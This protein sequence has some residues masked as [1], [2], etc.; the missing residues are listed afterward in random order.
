[1][2]STGDW[3]GS[4]AGIEMMLVDTLIFW[5]GA[6]A[7]FNAVIATFNSFMIYKQSKFGV[8]DKEKEE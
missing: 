8:G 7:E 3:F 4:I 2:F 6:Y 1:M 5:F